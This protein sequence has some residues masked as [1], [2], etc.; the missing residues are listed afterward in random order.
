M[1][2][3]QY[4]NADP[5]YAN[6]Y[7][8][9]ALQNIIQARE[10]PDRRAF[11]L[12]CGNG[13]TCGMLFDLGFAVTGIDTSE[14]GIARA[15]AAFPNVRVHVGSAYDNLA[16]TYG[17]FPLVVS[18]EVIEHCFDPRTLAMTFLSLIAPD[19]IGF[20]STPYHSYLKNL[21]L[22][23]SGKMERHFTVLWGGGHIKFFSINTLSQLLEEIGAKNVSFL[24][25]GRMPIL[26][27]S[28]V[29]IVRKPK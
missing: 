4:Y 13:A 12:G 16:E 2:S 17:T 7:L 10:W 8:W 19:G 20:L 22:A 14:S 21:V 28:M 11:D 6:S 24:R 26:A 5:T 25:V 1:I 3:Y 23:L 29:A 9:P 27:K 15:K 18:L